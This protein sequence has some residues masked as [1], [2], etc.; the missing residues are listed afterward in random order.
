MVSRALSLLLSLL[1]DYY[2]DCCS[3]AE[4][5]SETRQVEPGHAK[6][7]IVFIRTGERMEYRSAPRTGKIGK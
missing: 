6:P 3:L 4:K 5:M 7:S 2:C 1:L